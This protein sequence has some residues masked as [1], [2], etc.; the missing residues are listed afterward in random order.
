[1]EGSTSILPGMES[2]EDQL[3]SSGIFSLD[4][5][6]ILKM[7]QVLMTVRQTRPEELED[8]IIFMSM[9]NDID[10]TKKGNYNECFS[11]NEK[12]RDFAKKDL[13]WDIGLFSVLVK[14]KNGMERTVTNLKDTGILDDC[15]FERKCPSIES[16]DS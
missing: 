12:V 4:T 3:S 15:Q 7:V 1:M 5:L 14:K 9:F 8:R 13:R 6:Q 2:T 11:N 16:G 10:W